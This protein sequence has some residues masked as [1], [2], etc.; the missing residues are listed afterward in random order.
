MFRIRIH[1]VQIRIRIQHFRLNSDPDQ[2]G[3]TVL[4]RAKIEKYLQLKIFFYIIWSKIL[5]YLSLGLHKGR[6]D[7]RRSFQPSKHEKFSELFSIFVC[8]FCPPGS[9][10]GSTDLTE[11]GS[12]TLTILVFCRQ[13]FWFWLLTAAKSVIIICCYVW[14]LSGGAGVGLLVD[15]RGR[16]AERTKDTLHRFLDHL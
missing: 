11:S 7:C 10:S 15:C 14:G 2:S 3:S 9:G 16:G 4:M 6:P 13:S 5:M 8:P 12:E 1:W